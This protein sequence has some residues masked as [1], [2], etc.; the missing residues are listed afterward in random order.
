MG[1]FR[2]IDHLIKIGAFLLLSSYAIGDKTIW[3]NV[4]LG[5]AVCALLISLIL[6]IRLGWKKLVT[7]FINY[8]NDPVFFPGIILLWLAIDY[9]RGGSNSALIAA[10]LILV[11]ILELSALLM[12][13]KKSNTAR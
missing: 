8:D 10:F 11:T 12:N 1:N 13:R 4:L 7:S 2:I 6:I 3:S 9:S 5:I